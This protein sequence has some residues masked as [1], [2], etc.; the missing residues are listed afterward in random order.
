LCI[1]IVYKNEINFLDSEF[2][3]F[4]WPESP[5]LNFFHAN[6]NNQSCFATE[7]FVF[8]NFNFNIENINSFSYSFQ[9]KK[10]INMKSKRKIKK[11]SKIATKFYATNEFSIE[12]VISYVN[13]GYK[14]R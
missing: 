9:N 3:D 5:S 11:Q 14:Y 4:K 12:N 13:V 2:E 8:F 6:M 7:K 1:N 10:I